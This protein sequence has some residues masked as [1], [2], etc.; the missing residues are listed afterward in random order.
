[1]KSLKSR[2]NYDPTQPLSKEYQ[3]AEVFNAYYK[4]FDT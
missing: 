2:Y 1:M 3:D 4:C